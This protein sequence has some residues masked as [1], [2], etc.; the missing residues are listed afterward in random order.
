MMITPDTPP[1][2]DFARYVEALVA[3]SARRLGLDGLDPNRLS[4]AQLAIK[5]NKAEAHR[6]TLAQTAERSNTP[7]TTRAS[8]MQTSVPRA[9]RSE[10]PGF[11]RSSVEPQ[12]ARE[13]SPPGA[14][15]RPDARSTPAAGA[16]GNLMQLAIGGFLLVLALMMV[17]AGLFGAGEDTLILGI[18]AGLVGLTLARSA[19]RSIRRAQN[20]S[21][22]PLQL[23]EFSRN[24]T[25]AQ[26][27]S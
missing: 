3:E 12:G 22:A 6:Q 14:V 25:P 4:A 9:E 2:G 27:S 13:A 1:N 21:A 10:L 17:I 5:D 26:R 18:F 16:A 24:R 11:G 19:R 20:S 7:T 23:P 15:L 8:T